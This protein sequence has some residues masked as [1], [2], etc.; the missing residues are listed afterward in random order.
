[1]VF[2]LGPELIFPDPS[3]ADDD[4]LLA[5]GGDLSAERLL[6]AYQ[7][8]IFP[9]YSEGDPICWYSP[10]ERFVIYADEVHVS[11]STQ[12]LMRSG[13]YEVTEDVAFDNVV[14]LCAAMPRPGQTGTWITSE[15][16][17]AYIALH[18]RGIAHSVEIWR[19][20]RPVGGIYGVVIGRVFCGESMYSLV[21]SASKLALIH[22][23]RSGKYDLIDCQFHTPHLESMGGRYISRAELQRHLDAGKK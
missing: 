5:V 18:S 16:K 7:H 14:D 4:G 11:R 1:M 12:R 21:P 15:M 6:L 17:D 9:W 2:R 20:H 8:G 19:D 3:L 13:A 22:L 10:H 23:C